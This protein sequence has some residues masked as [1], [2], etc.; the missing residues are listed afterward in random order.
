MWRTNGYLNKF[1][2]LTRVSTSLS[3]VFFKKFSK[4]NIHPLEYEQ[5]ACLF[6]C[7]DSATVSKGCFPLSLSLSSIIERAEKHVFVFSNPGTDPCERAAAESSL[8]R[9]KRVRVTP[10]PVLNEVD[11]LQ[12]RITNRHTSFYSSVRFNASYG[13]YGGIRQK[14]T[15][16]KT[17]LLDGGFS[18]AR[19]PSSSSPS[20]SFT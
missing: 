13:V 20:S 1:S 18:K 19:A 17:V 14:P 8:A 7:V 5:L 12:L 11:R 2:F 15:S 16:W 3:F 10:L 9:S 4:T 6:Y